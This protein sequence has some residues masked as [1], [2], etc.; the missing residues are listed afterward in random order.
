M[1]FVPF[2]A[3]AAPALA[4]Y[5][6]KPERATVKPRNTAREL[7]LVSPDA[8]I[9]Q[10]NLEDL[11]EGSQQLQT[12]ADAAGGNRAFGGTG[13]NATTEWLYQTLKATGYYNVYKQP[14]TDLFT[15]ATTQFTAA[16]EE[17]DAAYMTYGPSGDVTA[18]VVKVN[19]LGCNV[20]DFPA[21]VSGQI[22]L[23]LRGTCSF[24]IKSA[25]AKLA[26]AAGAVIYNNVPLTALAGTLG[27]VGDYTPTVGVTQEVG[28]GIASK[29]GNGTVEATLFIDA[30][31][32]NRTNYNVIAET[33]EGDHDNVL[34]LGGHTDSVYA[35][36]GINDD[37]SGTIG[38]LMTGLALTKFKVKNAVR[39]GFWG[40][41]EFGLLGSYHYMKSINGSLGGNSTEI[42]KIRAY[43]NFDM[44]AS[45]NY[46]L[47]IYDGDGS[48]F[49]FSGAPGSGKIE[50]DFEEF[51]ESR[52]L[53]HVPSVFS[54]RSDYAA[55]LE[56]GIPSG[57]LFTGAEEIKTEQEATL[58]GGQAGE[59]LDACY[60]AA[61]DDINN[62][63]HDAYLVNTQSIANSVAKYAVSFEGIPRA[64]NTLRKRGAE[65]ARL[66]S[67]FDDGG[68]AHHGQTCGVGKIA[69]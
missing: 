17:L 1:R 41:E 31:S 10:I 32:E 51:Y 38:T 66:L 55:F 67:R 7:Q 68:H 28:E 15:A 65:R 37:G 61:C 63:A 18:N 45:P 33:I 24:A 54:L 48:A 6:P 35:G 43:L 58:F 2:V 64:N 49:N 20:A 39:L 52:G 23:I 13:H 62:L 47:G 46:V 4:Q 60:H 8:L 57:G 59:P 11:L 30:I 12:F 42:N 34:M 25:N 19:N 44:I 27:G 9:K 3:L 22:A 69:I 50:K 16:G 29:L 26:G 21:D 40:A 36:P 5:N 14:F 53:A 56:N